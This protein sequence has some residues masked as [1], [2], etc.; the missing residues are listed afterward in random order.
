[1][2]GKSFLLEQ[3]KSDM[4]VDLLDPEKEILYKSNPKQFY[5]ELQAISK[6][7]TII[8]DEIQ[9]V[10]SLLDYV[11]IGIERLGHRF[12]L[13]GSSAR[14][15]KKSG[16]NLL[17]GRAISLSLHPLSLS[18]LG[19]LFNLDWLLQYGSLP[20]IYQLLLEQR[21]SEAK[22]VLRTYVSVYLKEEIQA[23]AIVRNLGSFSRF[24]EVAAQYSGQ[25][26]VYSN[27]ATS[28]GIPRSTVA[29]YFDI[30]EDTLI[31]KRVWQFGYSEKDKAKPKFYFFDCGLIRALLDQLDSPPV[32]DH[33]GSLFETF[34]FN[35]LCKIRD[36]SGRIHRISYWRN[37]DEEIDFIIE[38]GNKVILAI[39]C[40]SGRTTNQKFS[41]PKFKVAFPET[42]IVI[43]SLQDERA[44]V[45]A[46]DT[47]VVPWK[48]VLEQYQQL[49]LQNAS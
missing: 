40:K 1:M 11:Q 22:A 36:Y 6:H 45:V 37:G 4:F 20:K 38:Q 24:L 15:L 41:F 34:F 46:E 33:K 47:T 28:A 31:G 42:A 25:I 49:C 12:L 10:P 9:R 26:V 3:I 16:V 8:V 5:Q 39:E 7:S 13:S 21:L 2:T 35:E 17:G 32:A 30:V 29:G 48:E 44:R 43:A 18:E 23:E 27:I 14:K 19:N